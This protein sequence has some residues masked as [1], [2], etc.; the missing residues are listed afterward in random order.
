M[1]QPMFVW[2]GSGRARKRHVGE[3]GRFLDEAAR[4][5]LPVPAGAVLLDEFYRFCLE[6]DLARLA[7]ERLVIPDVELWHNTLFHSVRLPPF[8][9]TAAVRPAGS[10]I[11][12]PVLSGPVARLWVDLSDPIAAAGAVS[13]VWTAVHRPQPARADVL[14]MEMVTA[15]HTGQV[16]LG[17]N[18]TDEVIVTSPSAATFA[19]PR[20]LPRRAPDERLFPFARRLQMLLRGIRRTFGPVVREIE[21]ADDGAICYL[22]DAS[23]A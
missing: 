12:G 1:G 17:E 9:R 15:E 23:A 21:W 5:G 11:D 20:L 3:K 16:R 7:G 10:G 8:A 13:A 14:I 2:L 18:D 22:I 6:H 4:A 19:V